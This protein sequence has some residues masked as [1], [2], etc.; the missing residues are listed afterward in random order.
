M[1]SRTEKSLLR[2]CATTGECWTSFCSTATK[3]REAASLVVAVAGV[4]SG[5]RLLEDGLTTGERSAAVA[6]ATTDNGSAVVSSSV[7]QRKSNDQ[8]PPTCRSLAILAADRH[9]KQN[10]LRKNFIMVPITSRGIATGGIWV[11]IP[12]KSV[13]VNF[14]LGKN[15]VRT[16][17]EHE[18]WSVIPPPKKKQISNYTPDN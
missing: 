5:G 12:T 11:Y 15:N 13:Q 8:M 1:T 6:V 7:H 10:T 14:L 9:W 4:V 17:I 2:L 3:R 16:G 18:Y